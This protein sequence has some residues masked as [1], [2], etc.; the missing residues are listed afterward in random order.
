MSR[1]LHIVNMTSFFR[2]P[3]TMYALGDIRL[4]TPLPLK[5]VLY[6]M[7][8]IIVWTIPIFMIFGFHPNPWFLGVAIAPP[9]V[10]AHYATKSV[11]QG[12]SL[13]DFIRV[14]FNYMKDPKGWTDLMEDDEMETTVYGVHH[15]IWISR[16]REYQI[17][18]TL[19][20]K[21]ADRME[22]AGMTPE[23]TGK[24]KKSSKKG[25]KA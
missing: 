2:R 1:G 12:R 24:N 11:W 6:G 9:L 21:R 7:V 14:N 16:R 17:I 5:K 22:A 8:F 15:E 20:Q 25:D 3:L 19:R 23:K 18:A 13:L 10:L 4:P